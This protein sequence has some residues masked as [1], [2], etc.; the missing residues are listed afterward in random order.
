M[1]KYDEMKAYYEHRIEELKNDVQYWRDKLFNYARE[2]DINRGKC[3]VYELVLNKLLG[4]KR[5]STDEFFMLDGNLYRFHSYSL[6]HE[7]DREDRLTV[8][9]IRCDLLPKGEK[10]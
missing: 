6:D 1:S 9:F 3:D 7:P 4:D 10:V 5:T 2:V 8:E